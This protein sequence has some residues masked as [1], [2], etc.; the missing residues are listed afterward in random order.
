MLFMLLNILPH[1][2][3]QFFFSYFPPLKPRCIL[4]SKKYSNII[5]L[6]LQKWTLKIRNVR[7]IQG[8][9]WITMVQIKIS[10]SDPSWVVLLVGVSSR[11]AKVAGLISGQGT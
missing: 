1:F 2:L 4:W 11:K 9:N 6:T 5:I 8:I 10:E 7:F 3:L